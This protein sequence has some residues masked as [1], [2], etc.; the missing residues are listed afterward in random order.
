MIVSSHASYYYSMQQRTNKCS[1]EASSETVSNDNLDPILKQLI[2]NPKIQDKIC[3]YLEVFWCEHGQIQHDI[4][5]QKLTDG[6]K[7]EITIRKQQ[8]GCRGILNVSI[9]AND[10]V[11]LETAIYPIPF[12]KKG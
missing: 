7:L 12:R 1:P 10:N 3:G 9:L 6:S 11:R 8:C 5:N 2:E 4:V